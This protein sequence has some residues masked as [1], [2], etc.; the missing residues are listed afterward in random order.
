[1]Y[2]ILFHMTFF[3]PD[4][5]VYLH[6]QLVNNICFDKKVAIEV[7]LFLCGISAHHLR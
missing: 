3:P 7:T 5:S 4:I 2:I 1:M 6:V